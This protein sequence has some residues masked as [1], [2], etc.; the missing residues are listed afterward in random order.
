MR[1]SHSPKHHLPPPP[2]L[3]RR[4]RSPNIKNAVAGCSASTVPQQLHSC[5]S[6]RP[7]SRPSARLTERRT[8]RLQ[9]RG[10]R[11][12]TRDGC[13]GP[14]CAWP[15]IRGPPHVDP[16]K[17]SVPSSLPNTKRKESVCFCF[18]TRERARLVGSRAG[19][20]QTE[21]PQQSPPPQSPGAKRAPRSPGFASS[22]LWSAVNDSP[23][24]RAAQ[25]RRR[26]FTSPLEMGP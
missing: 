3:L 10:R 19:P 9:L 21:R 5:R 23:G 4:K 13:P 8:E 16:N 17:A 14:V 7:L 25:W 15:H 1:A 12:A 24:R 22:C 20:P 2:P 26:Q 18:L 6:L 11:L